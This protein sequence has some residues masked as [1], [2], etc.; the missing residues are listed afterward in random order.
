IRSAAND[1]RYDF[2]TAVD[3]ELLEGEAVGPKLGNRERRA[4]VLYAAGHPI[5]EVAATM[6]TTEDTVKSYV[7]RGRRKYRAA[8]IDIG[9]RALLR[10]RAV[11]EG[12][13]SP[14]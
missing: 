11:V 3:T 4:L 6:G 8:G 7:K 2:R 13:L 1:T 9:T 12:W 14:E 10:R 5:K